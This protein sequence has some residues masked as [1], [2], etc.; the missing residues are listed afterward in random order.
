METQFRTTRRN[1][2]EELKAVRNERNAL[3]GLKGVSDRWDALTNKM[4]TLQKEIDSFSKLLG[5]PVTQNHHQQPKG[6]KPGTPYKEVK[7]QQVQAGRLQDRNSQI[8]G[9]IGRNSVEPEIVFYTGRELKGL[10]KA[11]VGQSE[12]PTNSN[13]EIGDLQCGTYTVA[14]KPLPHGNNSNK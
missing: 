14:T 5:L 10:V 9:R 8:I 11:T 12:L 2:I 13:G 7:K 4:N 6:F 1:K 3:K